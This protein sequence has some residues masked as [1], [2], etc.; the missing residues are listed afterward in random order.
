M[1]DIVDKSDIDDIKFKMYK[2]DINVEEIEYHKS[3]GLYS[4]F[5]KL[6]IYGNDATV[7]LIN[8]LRRCVIDD[9][10]C[11]A[12]PPE[13]ITIDTNTCVAFNNDYMRLRL[14]QLPVFG[15]DCNL[16]F[17]SEKYWKNVNY[18]D[19]KREKHNK[20]QI[21]EMYINVHNNSLE[22][23]NVTTDNISMYINGEKIWP[24][25]KKYPILLVKLKPND[26]FKCHMK[27]VLGVG[28][29]NAIWNMAKNAYYDQISD[30]K[31][32]NIY[33]FI[34]KGNM[35]C[36]E[37]EILIRGCKYLIKRL[38]DIKTDFEKKIESKEIIPEKII[39]FNLKNENHTIGEILNYEF[40]DHKDILRSGLIKP[41]HLIKA[42]LIKIECV[43]E[44][45]SPFEPMIDSINNLVKKI[46]HF[47]KA[48]SDL[49]K[50]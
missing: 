28:S 15:I 33:E 17:I 24:Y 10:P 43:P 35:Q 1:S 11:Y 8:S 12:I 23:I 4:S 22:I 38:N 50:K 9:L 31:D 27:A 37:H 26:K 49:L 45:K 2:F 46:S 36:S 3:N 5:L 40:Q 13:L 47:G 44:L 25:S 48:I 42:I 34:I 18:A 19:T 6:K 14:S 41:D 30:E 7:K 32:K 29:N 16:F 39:N 21:V 20:E